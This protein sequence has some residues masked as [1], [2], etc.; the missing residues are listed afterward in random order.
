LLTKKWSCN[1]TLEFFRG[2]NQA[3]YQIA[4]IPG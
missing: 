1:P 4:K 2:Y 3:P